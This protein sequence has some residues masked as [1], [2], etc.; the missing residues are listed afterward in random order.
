WRTGDLAGAGEAAN[1]YLASGQEGALGYVIAAEALAALGRPGEARR[2]AGRALERADVPLDRLFAGIPRSG[3]WP[4]DPN[5]P[6]EPAAVLFPAAPGPRRVTPRRPTTA[7]F[8][9]EGRQRLPGPGEGSRSGA[10]AAA[11]VGTA[12]GRPVGGMPG[13]SAESGPGAGA[14]G[15]GLWDSGGHVP[16]SAA[17]D[18]LAEIEDARLALAAGRTDEAAIRLAIAL[19]LAP[20]LAPAVLDA[21]GGAAGP[22]F[23]LLRGDAF[24]LVGHE[25]EARRA[26]A[27]AA[28]IVERAAAAVLSAAGGSAVDA[29]AGATGQTEDGRQ[30]ESG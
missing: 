21:T 20:A 5:D 12:G 2:L 16:E 8:S 23:E 17:P 22:A 9:G 1:A 4:V 18:P 3:V 24:R 13:S 30:L 19:R 6:G 26:Y 28:A 14:L 29:A 11:S 27:A 25:L 10:S 7:V 15:P